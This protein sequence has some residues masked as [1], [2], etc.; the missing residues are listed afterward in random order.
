MDL[1][2]MQK[3]GILIPTAGQTEQEYLAKNLQQNKIAYCIDQ[4]CFSI[5]EA[6]A[7]A[8]KFNYNIPCLSSPVQMKQVV[9]SFLDKLHFGS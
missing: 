3:K 8:K 5:T 4:K 9:K 2:Q 6:L 1:V 7:A